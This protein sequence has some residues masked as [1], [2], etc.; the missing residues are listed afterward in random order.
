VKAIDAR[1]ESIEPFDVSN[2]VLSINRGINIIRKWCP[3][4]ESKGPVI[5]GPLSI[6]C[7]KNA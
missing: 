4:S 1:P 3:D 7:V 5:T 6:L 2:K